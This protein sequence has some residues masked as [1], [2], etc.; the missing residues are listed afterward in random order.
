[1]SR[2]NLS[3]R[4]CTLRQGAKVSLGLQTQNTEEEVSYQETE[5]EY[6]G[7]E[8]SGRCCSSYQADK[9]LEIHQ[10]LWKQKR[11][12]LENTVAGW[13]VSQGTW[14]KKSNNKGQSYDQ[15]TQKTCKQQHP[16]TCLSRVARLWVRPSQS[17]W[18]WHHVVCQ[19]RDP[20]LDFLQGRVRAENEKPRVPWEN[21]S[22]QGQGFHLS[23]L[24][25]IHPSWHRE[26]GRQPWLMNKWLAVSLPQ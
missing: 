3:G 26:K 20:F 13:V 17:I 6:R 14:K 8:P 11:D 4:C 12:A 21:W 24:V 2:A 22:I 18:A 9:K 16:G 23:I 7:T 15:R 25:P 19:G 1:M 5:G 10:H